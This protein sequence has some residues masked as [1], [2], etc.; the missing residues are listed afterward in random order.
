MNTKLI[1]ASGLAVCLG[2]WAADP[3]I[4]TVNG[5]DV[6]RSEFEYLYHKNS[7]QQLAPQP[8]EDYVEMFKIYK[9]KVADAKA[10]GLDTTASFRREMTQYRNDLSAP[11]MADSTF[12]NSLVAQAWDRSQQEAEARHIMISK[13]RSAAENKAAR[14][15]ADSIRTL[16]LGGADFGD[17]ARR[18]SQDRTAKTNGGYL[19]YITVGHFP[20]DFETAV[21]TLSEGEVSDVV[22]SPMAYHVLLGGKKRPARGSVQAS[23]IMKMV[24]PG[25]PES[26]EAAAKAAIDSLW[27]VVNADPSQFAAVASAN[28]DD[29][30]SARNGGQLPWFGAG[31]MVAPFD[32]AAFAMSVGEISQPVRTQFGWHIIYKTDQ[33]GVPSL[34]E[35]KPKLLERISNPQDD[36]F[37]LVKANQTARLAKKHKGALN[38]KTRATLMERAAAAGLDSMFYVACRGELGAM[39]VAAIGKR[40][41]PVSELADYMRGYT[42]EDPAL[43]Q[44]SLGKAIDNF[45]ASRLV[46]TEQE[47]LA[48][49]QPEYRNLLNE[50]HDGSLLYEASVL[51][52]WD[53]ASKDKEGLERFFNAHRGDY[54][55]DKPHA[56]GILVQA[57]D[58]ET[59]DK[60]RARMDEVSAD[61]LTL[62][63][64]KEFANKATAERVLVPE[65][66]NAM[67]DNLLFGGP[68]AKPANANFTTFFMYDGRVLSAPEEAADV[69][70][71]VTSDYQNQLETEWVEQLKATYPV[72]VN[73]K[74]LKK[75]K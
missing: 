49:H 24:Q 66:V 27:N 58:Q 43:A 29:K 71:M 31:E 6:T 40:Q 15:K 21:F 61:S 18:E 33:K 3:V 51:K 56:K 8:L 16:L 70:G 37:R 53:K 50:Y 39:P 38:A 22:E 44:E 42:Q 25:A 5:V 2:A 52:V 57:Q 9:L 26:A 60:V 54:T 47:W 72:Q 68:E 63:V 55:W 13:S 12:L 48:E 46:E 14:A 17:L 30:G 4:M 23:H 59:A 74:A 69:R 64:R 11:Y 35:M 41:L 28:S 36:R 62:V 1:A 32:S 10:E 34:Q 67:V 7:Q 75:V 20:Y 45:Y 73:E 65:G 19:G